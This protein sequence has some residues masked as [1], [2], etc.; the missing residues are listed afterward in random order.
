MKKSV[1]LIL[2]ILIADQILKIWIKT[3]MTIG[4]EIRVAGDWFII[5][6]TENEG[7]AFGL[8][9]GGDSGKLI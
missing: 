1:L 7:M 4:Q 6:F 3:G 2:F 8:R 9:F 5:H